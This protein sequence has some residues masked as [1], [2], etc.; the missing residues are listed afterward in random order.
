MSNRLSFGGGGREGE[1][2]CLVVRASRTDEGLVDREPQ[3]DANGFVA[4]RALG[5]PKA[6]MLT[7]LLLANGIAD[8]VEAQHFFDER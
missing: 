8:P 2:G 4:A 5:V 3:D 7:A 6:R 1:T